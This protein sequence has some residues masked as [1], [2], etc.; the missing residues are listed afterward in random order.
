MIELSQS[1]RPW[2]RACRDLA[3]V[4][5]VVSGLLLAGKPASA[6]T[7]PSGFGE[8]TLGGTSGAPTA[9]D[10]A[11]DGRM[12]IAHKNGLVQV[13]QTNGTVSNLLDLS[14]KV[15]ANS[16]R[17]LLGLAA[18]RDF[19]TNGYL[20][21]LYVHELNPLNPDS[22]DPMASRLTRV[23]VKSNNTVENPASPETVILGTDS[24]QTVPVAGQQRRL[25]PGRLLLARDRHGAVGP[26]RRDPVGRDRRQ[27]RARRGRLL[28]PSLRPAVRFAGKIIHIDRNGHGLPGH[29]F[30]PSDTDLSTSAPRSTPRA[31]ATRSGSRFGRAA[32]PVVGDVGQT[33]RRSSTSSAPG[34]N[35]GWPCYEGPAHTA[36]YQSEARCQQE[37]AKE[38]T[39]AAA[40]SRRLVVSDRQRRRDRRRA[41]STRERNYPSSYD[42]KLFIADYVRGWIKALT[43]D[44]TTRSSPRSRLRPAWGRSSTWSRCRTAT[45]PT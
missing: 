33:S 24:D 43:I 14:A 1:Q 32:G 38:G 36:L 34:K 12:F 18:D 19:A 35:Y 30:C 42:G 5:L 27:P 41:R 39:A 31:S 17:G 44:P 28:L 20:Y 23:I 45:S 2:R 29:P 16:D 25:H 13:R 15:N 40:D 21:L 22:P 10:W 8:T 6:A 37:Y 26:R 9:V 7:L 3:P 4:F 11:P